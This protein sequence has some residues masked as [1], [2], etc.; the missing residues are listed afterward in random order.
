MISEAPVASAG[1]RLSYGRSAWLFSLPLLMAALAY[2]LIFIH[3]KHV[4]QDGDTYSHVAA[5]RWILENGVVPTQDPFSYTMRGTAWTAFE[6]LSQV[7]L[8]AAHQLGGWTGLV[9]LTALAFAATIS[10]LTRA[11]LQWL[12]A[13]YALLFATLAISMT[14]GY[15]LAR[16]HMLAMPLMMIWD[17]RTGTR[18]RGEPSP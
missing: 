1:L 12:E 9:A 13:I 11:L 16:P 17:H 15:V 14:A 18:Q 8:A 4:L 7:I 3:D 6:W 2:L 5:G 10:L